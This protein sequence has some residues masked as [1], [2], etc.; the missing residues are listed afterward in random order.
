MSR[1]IAFGCSSTFGQGLPDCNEDCHLEKSK[2][3]KFAWPSVLADLLGLECVNMSAPGS[4][5]KRIMYTVMNFDFKESDT[6]YILWSLPE[7]HAI[8]S[9]NFKPDWQILSRK[10]NEKLYVRDMVPSDINDEL[11]YKHIYDDYDCYLMDGI[12]KDYIY[13][14][15]SNKVSDIKYLHFYKSHITYPYYE[16][17]WWGEDYYTY[18]SM[19]CKDGIHA[20]LGTHARFASTLYYLYY[21]NNANKKIV[22]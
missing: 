2:P 8:F 20:S 18:S 22:S 10:N 12:Y 6:V 13:R 15:L 11:Y 1:L 7:R 5:N 4:S 14:L 3:S 17:V 21:S 9:K 16:D 19:R